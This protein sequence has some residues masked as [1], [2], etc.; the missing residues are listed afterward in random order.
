MMQEALA[1]SHQIVRAFRPT[2][3]AG[4][5]LMPKPCPSRSF[6]VIPSP[7]YVNSDVSYM[8]FSLLPEN[9]AKYSWRPTPEARR[10][11]VS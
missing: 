6:S 9:L 2:R 4:R 5:P 8:V 7:R 10:G 11:S 3:S 1:I